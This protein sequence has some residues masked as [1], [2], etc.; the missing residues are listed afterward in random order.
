MDPSAC[1]VIYIDSRFNTERWIS[2]DGLSTPITPQ[3]NTNDLEYSKLPHDLQ[4]NVNAFLTVFN[5]GTSAPL[6]SVKL[7]LI[8]YQYLSAIP[9]DPF[10]RSSPNYTTRLKQTVHLS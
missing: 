10:R 9:A 1:R 3:K 5:Q 6:R 8:A 2:R 7:K 4:A